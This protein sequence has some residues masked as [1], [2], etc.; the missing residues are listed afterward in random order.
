MEYS[1]AGLPTMN[2]AAFTAPTAKTSF[3]RAE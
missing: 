3:E 2:S 1:P